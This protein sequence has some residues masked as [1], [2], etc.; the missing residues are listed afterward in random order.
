METPKRKVGRPKTRPDNL[1]EIRCEV[2][3]EELDRLRAVLGGESQ[4]QFTRGAVVRE[5][6]RR[7]K[8]KEK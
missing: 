6:E 1:V 3:P 4:W 7:E 8:R 5:I 2:T